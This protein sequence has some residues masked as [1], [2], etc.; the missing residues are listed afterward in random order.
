L[1]KDYKIS[2]KNQRDLI[3]KK[4][5]E[6]RSDLKRFYEDNSQNVQYEYR[7]AKFMDIFLGSKTLEHN[8]R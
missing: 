3:K 1:D 2:R 5:L 4:I 7:K 6:S 8:I